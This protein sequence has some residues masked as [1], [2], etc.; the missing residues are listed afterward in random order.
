MKTLKEVIKNKA[1]LT[2]SLDYINIY[3]HPSAPYNIE[4]ETYISF[5]DIL[6]N[7]SKEMYE[8]LKPF[9]TIYIALLIILRS[10][11]TAF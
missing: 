10:Y 4:F 9:I 3:S 7:D 6:F 5:E 1:L 8:I 2:S 11:E